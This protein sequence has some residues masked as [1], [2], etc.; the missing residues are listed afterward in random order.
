MG[1][2]SSWGAL[3]CVPG[4][5]LNDSSASSNGNDPPA[6]NIQLPT[7]DEPHYHVDSHGVRWEISRGMRVSGHSAQREEWRGWGMPCQVH[8]FFQAGLAES[9]KFKKTWFGGSSFSTR[10][11][12]SSLLLASLNQL[13]RFPLSGM[14][15]SKIW[16]D[17]T[18]EFRVVVWSFLMIGLGLSTQHESI[19]VVVCLLPFLQPFKSI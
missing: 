1:R 15:G 9:S 10:L 4:V 5:W 14:P 11:F 16:R 19:S 7:D 13:S 3:P 2:G 6:L 17:L 12:H 18:I 8:N